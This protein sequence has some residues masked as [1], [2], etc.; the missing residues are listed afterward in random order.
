MESH[1]VPARGFYDPS[2]FY[3]VVHRGLEELKVVLR[4]LV[5]HRAL[6]EI[7]TRSSFYM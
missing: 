1:G 4:L 3:I 7:K 2:V 5:L 6:K